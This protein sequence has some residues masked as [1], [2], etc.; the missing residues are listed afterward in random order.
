[1]PRP[2]KVV[3]RILLVFLLTGLSLAAFVGYTFASDWVHQ[4]RYVENYTYDPDRRYSPKALQ[5]D[6]AVFRGALEESHG[7]LYWY[8]PKAEFDAAFEAAAERLD[9]PMT[10]LEFV[11]VIAP[12]VDLIRDGHT[13]LSPPAF[14]QGSIDFSEQGV[15]PLDLIV[16]KTGTYVERDGSDENALPPGT[17]ILTINGQEVDAVND[18]LSALFWTADG[19][20]D[21]AKVSVLGNSDFFATRYGYLEG[22]PE[23][24]D[25]TYTE[26]DSD[27]L[28]EITL[29]ALSIPK[30]REHFA[31]RYPDD[32]A[33]PATGVDLTWRGEVP[34]L[35]VSSFYEGGFDDYADALENAFTDI[36]Q[37]GAEQLVLDIRENGG[38]NEGRENLLFTYL[39]PEPYQKYAEVSIKV[40]RSKYLKYVENPWEARWIN[41]IYWS[42]IDDYRHRPDIGR[43]WRNADTYGS[44][45]L[46]ERE[47]TSDPFTGQVYLLLSGEVFSGGAEFATMAEERLSGL[48]TVGQET[49]GAYQG[50]TSGVA[51]DLILPNTHLGLRLPRIKYVM[52]LEGNNP[53]GRGTLPDHEVWPTQEDIAEGK[54]MVLEFALNLV[55]KQATEGAAAR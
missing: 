33:E 53:P 54:D 48:I 23:T 24:F 20:A 50:N 41:L 2:I 49:S 15:W 46:I 19:Y 1:M 52:K 45:N 38:G 44:H 7:G 29:E 22:F 13:N 16:T 21:G 25:V 42:Y 9:Q 28:K 12:L 36:Q 40:K 11:K 51:Y 47:P 32:K 37:R 10:E 27:I 6:F 55:E 31:E 39:S 4:K 17:E 18:E 35:T 3:L 30:I 5:E 26:L 14:Y 34:V 8:T 43:W